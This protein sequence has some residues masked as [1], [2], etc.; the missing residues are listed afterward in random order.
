MT[1]LLTCRKAP[2]R[3]LIYL[4]SCKIILHRYEIMLKCHCYYFSTSLTCIRCVGDCAYYWTVTKNWRGQFIVFLCGWDLGTRALKIYVP[5]HQKFP[6]VRT[7]NRVYFLTK[8]YHVMF[9]EGT[10][11]KNRQLSDVIPNHAS[12]CFILHV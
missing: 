9:V 4:I 3:Y 7:D 1:N 11:M 2:G 5:I 10:L 8:G 6:I 12:F